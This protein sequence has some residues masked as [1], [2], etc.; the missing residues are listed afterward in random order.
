MA[1]AGAL[2]CSIGEVHGAE[3]LQVLLERSAMDKGLFGVLDY[4]NTS[5]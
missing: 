5:I 3:V 2:V 4:M 1:L